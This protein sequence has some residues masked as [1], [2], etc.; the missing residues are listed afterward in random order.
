LRSISICTIATSA[1][2][3]V[4]RI[5]PVEKTD[6]KGKETLLKKRILNK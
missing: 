2:K 4:T 3:V 1:R 5:P 6:L